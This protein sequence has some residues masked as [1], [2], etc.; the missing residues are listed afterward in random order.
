M[1]MTPARAGSGIALLL[2]QGIAMF[3][4]L[5]LALIAMCIVVARLAGGVGIRAFVRAA[6]APQAVAAGTCSSMASL[7]ALMT[8]AERDLAID[9]ALA[10]ANPVDSLDWPDYVDEMG[11]DPSP[12]AG[13]DLTD[14]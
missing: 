2:G 12:P 3:A 9:P 11:K 14:R 4:I 1:R 10:R 13:E 7:P 8:A 5:Q 6:A